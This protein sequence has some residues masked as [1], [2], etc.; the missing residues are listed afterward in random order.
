MNQFE[1]DR[2]KLGDAEKFFVELIKLSEYDLRIEAMILKG[3]FNS[4][5]GSI[6]PNIQI[7][8]QLCRKLFD[9]HSYILET[10]SIR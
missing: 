9:N 7:L 3:E 2:E 4:L 5:L 1:G 10:S 6:R 8:N